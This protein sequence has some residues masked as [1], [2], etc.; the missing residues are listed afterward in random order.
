MDI[1]NKNESQTHQD[2]YLRHMQKVNCSDKKYWEST[3]LHINIVITDTLTCNVNK[4]NMYMILV[5]S[6]YAFLITMGRLI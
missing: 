3:Q 5:V 6:I 2:M 1:N 4:E